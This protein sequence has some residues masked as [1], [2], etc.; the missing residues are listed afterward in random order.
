MKQKLYLLA[1]IAIVFSACGKTLPTGTYYVVSDKPL[2]TLYFSHSPNEGEWA[3]T[4][5]IGNDQLPR[6]TKI[7]VYSELS[8]MSEGEVY[9]PV[10][11]GENIEDALYIAEKNLSTDSLDIV[12]EKQITMRSYASLITDT[13]TSQIGGL[14]IADSTY[15]VLGYDYLLPDGN[16][17]RYK[18]RIG[19]TEGY[20]YSKYTYERQGNAGKNNY[21]KHEAVRNPFGGG[22]AAGC[23]F[24]PVK[25]P[26][27]PNNPMPET[28]YSLYLNFSPAV[29]GKI[30][31]YIALAKETKINT[32]VLDIKDNQCPGYKAEA[33][34]LYSPTNY[35]KAGAKKEEMYRYAVQRL[36]EE[37]FYVV[38]RITCF[39]DSYF[40]ADH[41]E[42][43]ITRR[44]TGEPFFHNKAYWPSAYDRRVWQFNVELAKEVVRKFG[45][46]EV[47]FDYVRF[48]DKIYSKED[49]IN[50]NNYYKE[51]KV[52]AIQR[53]VQYACDE[54]HNVGAYVSID[55]FGE[56]T[57]KGYTTP[58]G[59][60]WPAISN[61][62]DV[63]CGM[64]YPDH[65]ADGY[66]G[67]SKPWNNPYKTL[68]TWGK[69]AV[70]RQAETPTPA[71]VR[72]WVQ[73]YPVMKHID[74][75]GIRYNAQELAQEIRGLYDAGI[76]DGYITWLASSSLER[77]TSQKKAFALDYLNDT[78]T[79]FQLDT[80]QGL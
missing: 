42:C 26:N 60:Y 4:P 25:K 55:V 46:N 2:V 47:N 21:K 17:N 69:K 39:K 67:I 23:D 16:V 77:Y 7:E 48:P 14:A 75:N 41:P 62:A 18:I 28:C 45:F 34:R 29:I 15:Q 9:F 32:F 36:H 59:Q 13:L 63:I 80:V 40:V 1:L 66:G 31:D 30:D 8:I 38:A 61:V 65:F 51:S 50:Y 24:Y 76:T 3:V 78:T 33:M 37:G 12:Q 53:F 74:K 70:Q 72:T 49:S 27:F 6:G 5:S 73:A 54:I 44:D 68:L 43:A 11:I 22:E 56:T 57:N 19:S 10:S 79:I 71:K 64:P 58:Y 20:I 52:Q 35:K